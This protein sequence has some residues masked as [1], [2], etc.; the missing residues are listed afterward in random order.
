MNGPGRTVTW[1]PSPLSSGAL[2]DLLGITR[3]LYRA[4]TDEEPRDA[5]RLAALEELGRTLQ[6]V[7]QASRTHSGT[8]VH[9]RARAAAERRY[10]SSLENRFWTGHCSDRA[11]DLAFGIQYPSEW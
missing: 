8:I 5:S 6:A 7:L 3:A 1:N 9:G 10:W 2:R 11:T 4:A